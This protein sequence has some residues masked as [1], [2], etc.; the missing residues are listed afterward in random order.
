VLLILDE[1]QTG[2][3]RTGHWFAYQ[4]FGDAAEPDILTCAKALA[5][6]IAAGVMIARRQVAA[7]LQPGM[8]ASTFGGNP[9]ACRAGA[10]TI[11]TIEKDGLLQRGLALGE[12]FRNQLEA[13]RRELPERIRQVRVSGVMI[14][15]ELTF[16]ASHVVSECLKQRLLINAIHGNVVRLLPAL[17]ISD[18]LIDQGCGIMAEVLRE[19][20][21]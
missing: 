3:G 20:V 4:Q 18:E 12:R 13:L 11:E 14:G 2:L 5:G 8:H 10:A 15:L 16:D 19:V 21:V 7:V 9:I 1:V 17:T 6:G